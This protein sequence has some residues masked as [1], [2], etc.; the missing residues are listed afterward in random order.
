MTFESRPSCEK[1]QSICG[2]GLRNRPSCENRPSCGNRPI[3]GNR[4]SCESYIYRAGGGISEPLSLKLHSVKY[5]FGSLT[6]TG[7]QIPTTVLDSAIHLNPKSQASNHILRLYS[8]FLSNV[9]ENP[10]TVFLMTRRIVMLFQSSMRT[11]LL[12]TVFVFLLVCSSLVPECSAGPGGRMRGRWR[13]RGRWGGRRWG[14]RG[15]GGRGWGWGGWGYPGWG[16][17]GG[18]GWGYPMMGWGMPWYGGGWWW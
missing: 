6:A 1:N 4:P 11:T 3:W 2:N 5:R 10:K 14:G 7:S 16:Y 18:Y 9:V 8:T 17:G 15:W 12:V 13:G